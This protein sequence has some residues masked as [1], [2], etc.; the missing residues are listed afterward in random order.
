MHFIKHKKLC[1]Y[2]ISFFKSIHILKKLQFEIF[3][4]KINHFL[5]KLKILFFQHLQLIF[6]K[7]KKIES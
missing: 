5:T 6:I 1:V 4:A 3:L 2:K 7:N